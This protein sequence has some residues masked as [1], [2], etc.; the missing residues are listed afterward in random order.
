MNKTTEKNSVAENQRPKILDDLSPKK[1]AWLRAFLK[2][3]NDTNDAPTDAETE[4][5][6]RSV[7]S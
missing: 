4:R 2:E 6:R 7:E 3:F 5:E 1:R